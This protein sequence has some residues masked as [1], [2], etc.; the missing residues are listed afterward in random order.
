MCQNKGVNRRKFLKRTAVAAWGAMSFPNIVPASAI[1]KDGAIAPSNRITLGFIGTGGHGYRKLL[2]GFL[3]ASDTESEGKGGSSVQVVAVCD[4]DTLKRKRAQDRVEEHYTN[5]QTKG[6]FKGC[7][8]YNDFRDLL[9]R[10]DIDAVVIATPEH[11]HAIPVIQAA[12]SGKDIYCEKPLSY[13]I[14]EARAMVNAVRRYGR[15]FQTGSQQRSDRNFR[16]ACELVRNGYIGEVQ[17]VK[18]GIPGPPIECNLPGE[19]VP[20]YL[21]WDLWLGP[22]LWRPY[23]AGLASPITGRPA[24]TDWRYYREYSG[25]GLTNWGAH[26]FDIAQWGMGMDDTGPVEIIPPDGKDYKQLT[27]KYANGIIMARIE[28]DETISSRFSGVLFIGTKG[29]VEVT[30]RNLRT[31]PENLINNQIGPNEIHLYESKNHYTNWLSCILTRSKPICDVEIG[32]R[33]VTIGHL[34]NIAYQLERPLKWD[35]KQ[36]LFVNDPYANRLL[37]RPM[38]SPWHL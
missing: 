2:R 29:R 26:H 15:V 36:E 20:H 23:N 27:Y 32:C 5:Q 18:I 6:R 21:D 16:F 7:M 31:W 14:A 35:P 9:A 33:S 22:A 25:G 24:G 1:G 10:D 3:S 4:V 17:T 13:S 28:S 12:Q 37:S 19:P 38:R 30:R 8:D 11:S 34:G